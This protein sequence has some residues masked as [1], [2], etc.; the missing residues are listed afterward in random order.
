MHAGKLV[1]VRGL[2]VRASPIRQLYLSM[3]YECTRC[4]SRQRVNFPEGATVRPSVCSDG[5][6]SRSFL[7]IL[8]SAQSVAWQRIRLQVIL[9]PESRASLLLS[10]WNDCRGCR[11][12]GWGCPPATKAFA[13]SF[14]AHRVL[15]GKE[16]AWP[17]V[18]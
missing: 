14:K 3:D 12:N 6:R 13:P 10:G 5:C 2:V 16:S 17:Q 9:Q 18:T 15:H 11:S 4:S 1:T 8:D 7:P